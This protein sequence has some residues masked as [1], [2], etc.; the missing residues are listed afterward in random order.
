M[1]ETGP[2]GRAPDP[3][4]PA[5]AT[6]GVGRGC[7]WSWDSTG[8]LACLRRRG[9]RER[10]KVPWGRAPSSGLG[11]VLGYPAA[12]RDLSLPAALAP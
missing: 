12:G 11:R 8:Q 10:W 6:G 5:R 4:L 7:G 9:T 3:S 1:T 2:K